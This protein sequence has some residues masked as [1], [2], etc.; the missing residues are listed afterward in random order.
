MTVSHTVLQTLYLTTWHS[1]R[2]TSL[3]RFCMHT[4]SRGHHTFL[5][6]VV[7]GNCSWQQTILP[8][9]YR[10]VQVQGSKSQQP[11]S[12]WTR[13]T[14]RPGTQCVSVTQSPVLTVTGHSYHTLS[15]T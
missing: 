4:S 13:V 5:Q 8:G 3:Q 9:R 6:H 12:R 2:G 7:L 15:C 11:G 10:D 14:T 1:S